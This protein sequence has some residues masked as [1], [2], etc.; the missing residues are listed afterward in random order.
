MSCTELY[1]NS[2]YP[3]HVNIAQ[4]LWLNRFMQETSERFIC[5]GQLEELG[6]KS[7]PYF[8]GIV[9]KH[10]FV[11]WHCL[12]AALKYKNIYGK[13][14]FCHLQV[15]VIPCFVSI[16]TDFFM[17]TNL[18]NWAWDG[19]FSSSTKATCITVMKHFPYLYKIHRLHELILWKP[20]H[21]SQIKAHQW[22]FLYGFK[23]LVLF[24]QKVK[25]RLCGGTGH[26]KQLVINVSF[27]VLWWQEIL[28][29]SNRNDDLLAPDDLQ[30]HASI[31][32]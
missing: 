18:G 19:C 6:P 24:L 23:C 31:S 8:R 4:H 2:T 28:S 26:S 11:K 13:T 32:L 17:K 5:V 22:I 12:N 1:L 29:S 10:S 30:S 15:K 27:F 25:T 20:I 16:S 14:W 3:L 9:M 7:V 21:I